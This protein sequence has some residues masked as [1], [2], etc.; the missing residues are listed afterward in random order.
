V[1]Y[2]EFLNAIAARGG[3]ETRE[4][5]VAVTRATLQTL[6]ERLDVSAAG[7]LAA[8][9]PPELARYV[10]RPADR[11]A[12]AF[13]V[14]EFVGRVAERADLTPPAALRLARVVVTELAGATSAARLAGLCGTLPG[15]WHALLDSPRADLGDPPSRALPA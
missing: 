6:A 1:D 11:R 14:T 9:L 13:D 2:R 7:G 15:E 10:A 12:E 8:E 4:R 5:A 3:L